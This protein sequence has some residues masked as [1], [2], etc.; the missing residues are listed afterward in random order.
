MTRHLIGLGHRRIGFLGGDPRLAASGLRRAGYEDALQE[1]GVAVDPLLQVPGSFTY[2]SGLE[3]AARLLALGK[4][5]TAIF[6]SNDDMAA[7][8]IAAA[9][10]RRVDVP[11][12]LTVCGFDDSPIASTVWPELTTIRQPIADMARL[13]VEMLANEVRCARLGES[14]EIQSAVLEVDLVRRG[15]DQAVTQS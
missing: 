8:T 3:G 5:P 13:A 15:S 7:G 6:A 11:S 12:Q 10:Q 1:A 14:P 2:R 9:H 4:P